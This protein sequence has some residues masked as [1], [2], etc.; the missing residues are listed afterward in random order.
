MKKKRKVVLTGMRTTGTLHLGHHVGALEQWKIIQ[1]A[2]E[3]E[4]YFLLADVQALTTHAN[5]PA[6]L[7]RS[8]IEV[9][10]DWM[11]AGIDPT[12]PHVHFVLQSQVPERYELSG[13]LMMIARYSEVMRNPTLKMELERQTSASMGFMAY[14]VD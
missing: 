2:G 11:A 5:D 9:T 3:H 14:P 7:T 4:C 6:L 13:L 10:R 12:L 8:V 1:D